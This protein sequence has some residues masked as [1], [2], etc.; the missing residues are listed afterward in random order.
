LHHPV[1][2]LV[3]IVGAAERGT[4]RERWGGAM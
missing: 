2:K 3:C 1:H 4:N